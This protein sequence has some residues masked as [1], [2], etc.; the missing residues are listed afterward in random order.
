[1]V[2]VESVA[3]AVSLIAPT[4]VALDEIESDALAVSTT[5]ALN[6]LAATVPVSVAVDVSATEDVKVILLAIE[7]VAVA[8]SAIAD[9]KF[10]EAKNESVAVADSAIVVANV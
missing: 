8:V 10:C 1:M 6:V 9:T 2:E 4:N 5:G 3:V 7:S